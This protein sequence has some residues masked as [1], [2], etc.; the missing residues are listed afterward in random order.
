MRVAVL[1]MMGG[2]TLSS[3]SHAQDLNTPRVHDDRAM[4]IESFP[5]R[6]DTGATPP[7]G[8]DSEV[9]LP[10]A[11]GD[12]FKLHSKP[13]A[14]KVIYLDFDGHMIMWLGEE[15]YYV[16]WNLE[17][18]DTTFSD[19]ERTIIQ[20][21]WQSVAEDFLPFDLDVTT[22]DPGVE[23]LSNTGG[24][25]EEWG[26]RAVINHATDTYSWAYTDS[27]DDSEDTELFAWTGPDPSSVYE[28]WIWTADSVS[29]EAGHAL[30]LGHDGTTWDPGGYYVGHG[31]GDTAWSPIMGWTNYGLSQWSQGEYTDADNQEDDLGII[32]TQNGFGF[33]SDDH[34]STIAAATTVDIYQSP[35]AN[36]IIEQPE[37]LDFFDFPMEEDGH[38]LM[39]ISPDNL[40]P[41]LDIEAKLYDSDG[42]LLLTSNPST[43]LD[44]ELDIDLSAGD[45]YLS[46]DGTGYDD[47]DSDGY[48][49]YGTLGYFKIEASVEEEPD[50]SGDS[51]GIEDSGDVDDSGEFEDSGDVGDSGNIDDSEE[52]N[53]GACSCASGHAPWSGSVLLFAFL[54]VRRREPVAT[55]TG[56]PHH[57][58][59]SGPG[60]ASADRRVAWERAEAGFEG[61][62][63]LDSTG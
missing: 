27:F 22:E 60:S 42:T 40:A 1:V 6:T 32:T 57:G 46:V 19:T 3:I 58:A 33:R 23:A 31:S 51:G 16:P 11:L 55:R 12:T 26:I 59:S 28:T 54:L 18:E 29:H 52:P 47:P 35:V 4:I 63:C 17:G 7:P 43:A 44:A 56:E 62:W 13:D 24:D 34:G 38:L 53:L 41:N 21:T 36:G 50:D 5:R 10:A 15:F 2:L 30:G 20:L 49:D 9:E 48:S 45:Y 8:A 14:T 25:D 39:T 37:D 61:V